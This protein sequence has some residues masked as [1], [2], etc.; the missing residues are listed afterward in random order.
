MDWSSESSWESGFNELKNNIYQSGHLATIRS[1]GHG[2]RNHIKEGRIILE[3][4]REYVDHLHRVG[5]EELKTEILELYNISIATALE[6]KFFEGKLV[7][8]RKGADLDN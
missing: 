8:L 7:L 4:I 6:V 2:L 5:G 1:F 3:R